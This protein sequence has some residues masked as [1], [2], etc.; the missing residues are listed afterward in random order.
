LHFRRTVLDQTGLSGRYD[1]SFD[2]PMP[3]ENTSIDVD[4][5]VFR[6]L[7]DQL[8][9]KIESRKAMVDTLVIEHLQQPSEN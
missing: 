1:I 6:A 3:A 8:G 7:D 5:A 4:S 2:A 9:L